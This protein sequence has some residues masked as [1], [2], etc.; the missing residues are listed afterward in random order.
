MREPIA[1]LAI[2]YETIHQQQQRD[3]HL[4]KS[5]KVGLFGSILE[6]GGPNL[7]NQLAF[8]RSRHP[9]LKRTTLTLYGRRLIELL[10]T[11]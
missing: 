8:R 9:K 7:L 6:N 5:W 1:T 2:P 4:A 11:T 10:D 3:T